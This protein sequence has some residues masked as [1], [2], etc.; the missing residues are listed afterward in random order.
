VTFSQEGRALVLE[1]NADVVDKRRYEENVVISHV[2]ENLSIGSKTLLCEGKMQDGDVNDVGR[3][4]WDQ[5]DGFTMCYS[6]EDAADGDGTM[7]ANQIEDDKYIE[8]NQAEEM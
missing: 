3:E 6:Q 8:V 2:T 4:C 7:V 5:I 1:K